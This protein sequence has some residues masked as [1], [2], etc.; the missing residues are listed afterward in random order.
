MKKCVFFAALA[1]VLAACS[2][3]NAE[4]DEMTSQESGEAKMLLVF[5]PYEMSE[6]QAPMRRAPVSISGVVSH[7]DVWVTDGTTWQTINTTS[8]DTGFG[9]VEVILD[10]SKTYTVYAMGHN[11]SDAAVRTGNVISFSDGKVRDCMFFSRQLQVQENTAIGCKMQRIVGRF[12][13][14]STDQMPADVDHVKFTIHDTSLTYNLDGTLGTLVDRD[15]LYQ[16]PSAAQNGTV[17]FAFYIMSTTDA[18][19]DFDIT[20]TAYDD[21]D[22]V[23][24]TRTFEDVPIKNGYKTHYRGELFTNAAA[25][26]TFTVDEWSEFDVVD[27]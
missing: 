13:I 27:F 1:C 7:L 9:Q 10:K 25:T 12:A 22:D 6:M 23:L 5:S 18:A 26:T 4:E 11:S 20:F 24:V 16:S 17:S 19:T 14:E 15:V 21:Q 2:S 3:I 8:N